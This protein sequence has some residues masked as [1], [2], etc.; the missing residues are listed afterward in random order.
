[1]K[2]KVKNADAKNDAFL[3]EISEDVKNDNLRAIWKKY[4][5][6]IVLAVAT[7][8]TITVSYEAIKAK[9]ISKDEE[10]TETFAQATS[11][12][13]QGRFP[14]A[15]AI[16]NTIQDSGHDIYRDIARIQIA[17]IYFEQ[18]DIMEALKLLEDIVRDKKVNPE[19]REMSAIKLATYKLDF[20]PKEEVIALLEPIANT[21]SSWANIA[22]EMLAM[23]Y[24]REGDIAQ[25]KNIYQ[26]ILDSADADDDLRARVKDMLAVL[27][28]EI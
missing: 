15:M 9:K 25:A 2:K 6:W 13:N 22:K 23:L 4:G 11:L 21:D 28:S 17:N 14:E 27:N 24:I 5:L 12:Q 3:R 18:G 1:M 10:I 20:A 26:S 19:L 8:L 16:Y 7:I